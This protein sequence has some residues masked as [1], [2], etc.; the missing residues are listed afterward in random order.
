VWIDDEHAT[1]PN[2]RLRQVSLRLGL[3][4]GQ[5]SELISSGEPLTAGMLVVTG[6]VPPLS[7]L[8]KPGQ[9]IFQGGAPRG[10]RGN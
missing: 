9:N 10:G 2:K 6:V 8:P 7:A 1:D 3:T 4:D 5:F